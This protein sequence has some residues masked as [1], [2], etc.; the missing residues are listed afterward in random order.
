MFYPAV[1]AFFIECA[2]NPVKVV[3]FTSE[4]DLLAKAFMM[5]CIL[6]RRQIVTLY[7]C[8]ITIIARCYHKTSIGFV[9]V[10]G[11]IVIAIKGHLIAVIS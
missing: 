4:A 11:D 10:I 9:E 1:A 7:S 6:K 3:S 8:A 2:D 5:F